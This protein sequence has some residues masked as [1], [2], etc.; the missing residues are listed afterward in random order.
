MAIF[1]AVLSALLLALATSSTGV[2]LCLLLSPFLFSPDSS[3]KLPL[4]AIFS[5]TFFLFKSSRIK[6]N[7]LIT[8][9][10]LILISIFISR[11][12]YPHQ[13]VDWNYYLSITNQYRGEHALINNPFGKLLHNKATLLLAFANHSL[14]SLNP[15]FIFGTG[16]RN[17]ESKT[18]WQSPLPFSFLF[19]LF[20]GKYKKFLPWIIF[21]W[22]LAILNNHHL[23]ESAM[24]LPFTF[25]SMTVGK[26]YDS[27]TS[28]RKFVFLSLTLL[29][30]LISY[31]Y[32]HQLKL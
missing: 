16:D 6:L 11:P 8:F 3:H 18:P 12:A 2:F 29:Y 22:I 19:L 5:L 7:Q 32:L 25:V 24:F 4:L 13:Q 15:S 10:L 30:L 21:S 14:S 26:N 28:S 17:P 31:Y 9:I 23:Y 20:L 1:L 27:L